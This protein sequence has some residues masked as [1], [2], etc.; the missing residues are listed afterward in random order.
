MVLAD[1]AVTAILQAARN[2]LPA[3]LDYWV[4]QSTW[5]SGCFFIVLLH[6]VSGRQV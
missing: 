6:P 2:N 5:L 4:F 3:V 1:P